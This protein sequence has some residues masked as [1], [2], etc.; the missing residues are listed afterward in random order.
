[1][2]D[3]NIEYIDI[4][5][6]SLTYIFVNTLVKINENDI[7]CLTTI[8]VILSW[9]SK[10]VKTLSTYFKTCYLSYFHIHFTGK[11]EIHRQTLNPDIP[12]NGI[13][14]TLQLPVRFNKIDL[15]SKLFW[16]EI[17]YQTLYTITNAI[18]RLLTRKQFTR[19]L[20]RMSLLSF[21]RWRQFLH[22]ILWPAFMP[23]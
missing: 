2:H 18:A 11:W 15:H 5:I 19:A 21:Q 23:E 7:L 17:A 12:Y 3:S 8:K 16:Q 6:W 1:M 9:H 14:I 13:M 22:R 20:V 4:T 10:Y